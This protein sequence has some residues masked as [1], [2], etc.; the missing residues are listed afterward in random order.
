MG[1]FVGVTLLSFIGI[2]SGAAENAS[3]RKSLKIFL[4]LTVVHLLGNVQAV[5]QLDIEGQ[6]GCRKQE[7]A[8]FREMFLPKGYPNT[9]V[10]SYAMYRSWSLCGVLVG[11]P[12]QIDTRLSRPFWNVKRGNE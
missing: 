4:L 7:Q 5:R 11:Y 12:K 9:V 3:L 10:S 8:G 6:Q 2:G 1:L